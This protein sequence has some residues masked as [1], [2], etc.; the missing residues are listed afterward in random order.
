M[1]QKSIFKSKTFYIAALQALLGVA[2]VF[3]TTYP[4]VGALVIAKSIIDIF[5][6]LLTE[7][8]VGL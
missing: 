6:R 3:S 8:P 5:L 4:G 7:Q 2:V 1:P